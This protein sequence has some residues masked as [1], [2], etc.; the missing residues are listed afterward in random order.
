MAERILTTNVPMPSVD[1]GAALARV[2]KLAGRSSV[3]VGRDVLKVMLTG[4]KLTPAEYFVQGAWLG[5]ANEFVGA[6]SNLRLNE[7]LVA[8]G[9]ADL[10]ALLHDKYL[11][12]LV[13]EANGFPVPVLKA[14][15]AAERSFGRVPTL[16]T[17]EAL[18][19][20]MGDGR[21]LP[22]FAKPVDGSMALASVPLRS[23]VPGLVDIGGRAVEIA[24][25]AR[26]VAQ[27]FPRGWLIQ[28]LLKQPAEIEALIGPGV[29]TVRVVTLWEAAG[30][31]VLYA[32]WRHP[33][34]G[35]WVDAAIFGKP[36][37]GCALDPATGE[38]VAAH[39][40]DLFKGRPVTHSMVTP[41]L[42]LVGFRLPGWA[43]VVRICC[44]AHRLFPGHAL[45]GWDIALTDRGPVISELNANPLH[46]SY[47]RSFKRG[48]L[49]PEFVDRL[50]AARALMQLRVGGTSKK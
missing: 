41:E 33:A 40:G 18:A 28:E 34:V 46:M 37:V 38:V 32:V 23:A 3:Q 14:V 6:S 27:A 42:P 9:K 31:Q 1:L 4:Q 26:E 39:L 11:T 16:T 10:T 47:Q 5:K 20:W 7:S 15:Y 17:A 25:L 8:A 50:D 44:G 13:L 21:N 30:P 24:A 2:A 35:T 12:G 22:S 36:N 19:E 43:D 45:L 29:G 48:F 49:H